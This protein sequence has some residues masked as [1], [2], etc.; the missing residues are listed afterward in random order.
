ML[1]LVVEFRIK[2]EHI[3]AFEQAIVEN[4]RASRETEPGCRQFDVCRDPADAGL[5]FLYELYDDDAAIQAHLQTSHY[6]QMNQASAGWV[7]SK[8]VRRYVRAAPAVRQ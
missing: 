8:L 7:D 4:A 1:A 6:L 2:P 5:F 3:G